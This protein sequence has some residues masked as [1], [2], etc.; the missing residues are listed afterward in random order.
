MKQRRK[1]CAVLPSRV[2]AVHTRPKGKRAFR[3]MSSPSGARHRAQR[4][5]ELRSFHRF[6]RQGRR[7]V[8]APLNEGSDEW[9]A[10]T[11]ADCLVDAQRIYD[12]LND[13]CTTENCPITRAGPKYEY[14]WPHPSLESRPAPKYFDLLFKWVEKQFGDPSFFPQPGQA[15]SPSSREYRARMQII[16]KRLFRVYAHIYYEHFEHMRLLG[17]ERHLH[18]CFMEFMGLALDHCLIPERAQLQPL[19][20]LIEQ[21]LPNEWRRYL[22]RCRWSKMRR[23]GPKVAGFTS[24]MLALFVE[25][26]YRPGRP[27]AESAGKDFAAMVATAATLTLQGAEDEQLRCHECDGFASEQE[28]EEEHIWQVGS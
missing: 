5:Y 28:E 7:W 15:R 22:T 27:G 18:S 12:C 25:V 8:R 20:D 26:H 16:F 9:L 2:T 21:L 10:T 3:N 13:T 1:E 17:A 6:A 19:Q 14:L 24:L 4:N 23:L 11:A